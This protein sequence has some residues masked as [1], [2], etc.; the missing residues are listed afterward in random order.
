MELSLGFSTC[1]ND[2]FIFDAMVHG[3]VD[4]EGLT[5]KVALADVESLN[6]KA[7]SH[8]IHITKLSYHAYA[9]VAGEYALLHAGSALGRGVGPLLIGR[10]KLSS[11]EINAG[12]VAIPGYYTTAHL[13]FSLFY[14][15]VK[16]K[17]EMLFSRIEE[18]LL[19]GEADAGV[20]IHENRFTYARRGLVRIDD[21]GERWEAATGLPIPL[22]GIA[23][24]RSLPLP[25]RQAVNRIMRRSVAYAFENPQ[26][27]APFVKAHACEMEQD[28]IASHIGLYVNAFTLDLGEEGVMAVSRLFGEAS[29][30]GLIQALPA[31]GF[32]QET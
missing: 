26:A 11:A 15:Q 18:A 10:Q 16:E 5:F 8:D 12:R 1:P 30:L 28:V 25:V 9:R 17:P 22:G 24:D 29:R 23:V 6:R 19:S 2:T 3:R 27:S 7:F 31:D 20:I 14:P 32:L 21:L 13:L 4:T